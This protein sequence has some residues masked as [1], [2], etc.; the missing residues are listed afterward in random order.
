[1]SVWSPVVDLACAVL[2]ASACSVALLEGDALHYVAASGT[3]AAE[4]VGMRLELG[5]GIAGYVAATGQALEVE[6]VTSDP[7]F[8]RDVAERI[9]YVPTSIL[10]APMITPDGDLV[11]VLSVLDRA[12]DR[13]Q[14]AE[15][16]QFASQVA[17]VAALV[18]MRAA[19]PDGDLRATLTA[20]VEASGRPAGER[21]LLRV[22]A[23][24]LADHLDDPDLVP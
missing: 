17:D 15:A 8:A 19:A 20:R 16:V 9:G 14:G 6:Q 18:T 5:R 23:A 22:L 1:M 12:H 21:R 13:L 11:G 4:V 10:A 7:R 2:G 3:G 24:V